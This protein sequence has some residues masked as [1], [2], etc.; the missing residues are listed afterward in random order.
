MCITECILILQSVYCY[1][2]V[3]IGTGI[4]LRC[5][6]FVSIHIYL[7]CC[8]KGWLLF[9][10]DKQRYLFELLVGYKLTALI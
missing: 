7:G 8:S 1:Y 3:C 2:R 10:A 9:G 5:I 6:N 4:S